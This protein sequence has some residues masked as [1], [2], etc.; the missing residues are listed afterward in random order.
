M[1]CF[2]VVH[3]FFDVAYTGGTPSVIIDRGAD[4]D[5]GNAVF[6]EKSTQT[7]CHDGYQVCEIFSA[8]LFKNA[9]IKSDHGFRLEFQCFRSA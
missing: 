3:G 6:V 8:A 5:E 9:A 1:S 7:V 4:R 2:K